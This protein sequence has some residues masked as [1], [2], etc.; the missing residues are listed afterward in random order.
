MLTWQPKTSAFYS[1]KNI[2]CCWAT[3]N[4][5]EWIEKKL[6]SFLLLCGMSVCLCL[7]LFVCFCCYC[8]CCLFYVM[9]HIR[10]DE[11]EY[12]YDDDD[13]KVGKFFF[14]GKLFF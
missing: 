5:E 7:C 9:H 10:I 1:L 6:S 4:Q 13:G 2:P 11:D 8:C 14:Y 3:S 12:G